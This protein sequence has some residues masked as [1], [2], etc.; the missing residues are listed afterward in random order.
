MKYVE[1]SYENKTQILKFADHWVG[2]AVTIEADNVSAADDILKAG[3]VIGGIGGSVLADESLKVEKKNTANTLASLI[4][5]STDANSTVIVTGQNYT[6]AP[7][8]DEDITVELS[9]PSATDQI[10]SVDVSSEG[11]IT[12]NLATDGG[13]AI[14]SIANDV[15]AAINNDFEA[16]QIVKASILDAEDGTGLVEA[17]VA[18][19]LA[20]A[21]DGNADAAEGVLLDDVD[22]S[23][24]D[25]SGTMLVHGF[26]DTNKLSETVVDEALRALRDNAALVMIE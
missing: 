23:Y 9:D 11:A 19:A 26:V 10:L 16:R 13:G 21:V 22:I 6:G 4:I 18:S 7:S 14:T 25:A 2:V 17:A 1:T 24:G 8:D 5:E 12:V 20:G 15:V 3:S